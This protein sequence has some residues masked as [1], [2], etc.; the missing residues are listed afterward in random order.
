MA[1]N[2]M[3]LLQWY[4]PFPNRHELKKW[5]DEQNED[6]YLYLFQGK[7]K[8]KRSYKYYCGMTYTRKNNISCVATRMGD[9]NHHIHSF[10]KERPDTISIWIGQIANIKHPTQQDVRLCENMITSEMAQIEIDDFKVENQT[11][12]L[13]PTQNVYIINEWFGLDCVEY[14]PQSRVYISNIIQMS[15]HIMHQ[16]NRFIEPKG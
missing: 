15:F 10:E 11:N 1:S 9:T 14:R 3:F 2:N 12:K 13:A 4:G 7:R 8:N 6:F 16:Q 5:E